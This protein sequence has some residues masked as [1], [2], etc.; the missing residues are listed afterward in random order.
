MWIP[1]NDLSEEQK[2]NCYVA[3][4]GDCIY[5]NGDYAKYMTYEEWCKESEELGE[6]LCG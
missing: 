3:Y 2:H 1:F 4:V 5:E 6:A